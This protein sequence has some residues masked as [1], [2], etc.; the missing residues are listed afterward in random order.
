MSTQLVDLVEDVARV[1]AAIAR[2]AIGPS[3]ALSST[4]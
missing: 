4:S 3:L 1:F 2:R